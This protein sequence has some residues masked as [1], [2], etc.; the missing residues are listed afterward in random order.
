MQISVTI[1]TKNCAAILPEALRPLAPFAEVIVADTGSTDETWEAVS[2]FPNVQ[3]FEIPFDGFGPAHN[4]AASLASH[5]WILSIDSD[6][7]LSDDLIEEIKTLQLDPACVYAIGRDNYFNGKRIRGCSG[8]YPD[9]VVRLYNRKAARFT[10]DSV[11]EKVVTDGLKIVKL[12]H[13]LRHTPYRSVQDFITKMQI[14]STL[15]AEQHKGKKKAGFLRA[16]LHGSHAFLKSYIWKK[17]FLA[18]KE[19]YIISSY[20]GQTAFYK[21]LKL[22]ELNRK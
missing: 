16:L 9:T 11:H 14:Y 2:A 3:F 12:K 20:Q 4:I 17:G 19:G 1:L 5:D 18:G 15:F 10:D 8:W 21:Y 6:E 22:A 13:P 7:V